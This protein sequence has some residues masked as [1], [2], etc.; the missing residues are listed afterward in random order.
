MPE[1]IT[2]PPM[3]VTC[4][5]FTVAAAIAHKNLALLQTPNW[6]EKGCPYTDTEISECGRSRFFAH[7]NSK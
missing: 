7:N 3:T 5:I 6:T 1:P 2:P 4:L